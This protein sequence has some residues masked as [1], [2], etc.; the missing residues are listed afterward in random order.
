MVWA[1]SFYTSTG[2]DM[3]Q[4]NYS[5]NNCQAKVITVCWVYMFVN[6]LNFPLTIYSFFLF[7]SLKHTHIQCATWVLCSNT[8]HIHMYSLAHLFTLAHSISCGTFFAKTVL[9][10]GSGSWLFI[11]ARLDIGTLSALTW[12]VCACVRVYVWVYALCVYVCGCILLENNNF[13]DLRY[14]Q[15][16]DNETSN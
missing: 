15:T 11:V 6:N 4:F 14:V 10:V 13:S 7:C 3:K 16:L 12:M 2:W 1:Y 5:Y 9:V 8:H